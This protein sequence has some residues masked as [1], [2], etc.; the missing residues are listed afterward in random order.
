[1]NET[2]KKAIE[3]LL[4]KQVERLEKRM[5]IRFK[6]Q[7]EQLEKRMDIRFKEQGEQ[8]EKRMDIRFK[9]QGEQLEKRMIHIFSEG[10]EQVVLPHIA[11][12][13]DKISLLENKVDD[14]SFRMGNV[15]RKVNAII[16][17]QDRQGEEIKGIK[18][19]IQMPEGA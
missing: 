19:F 8:L 5:D 9:E 4:D 6:E 7:G 2:D 14:L 18:K 12:L 10:F 15:E 11:E 13:S 1:M 3:E 17:R 16:E